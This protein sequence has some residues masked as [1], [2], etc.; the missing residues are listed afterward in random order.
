MSKDQRT[1][2]TATL[3]S[4]GKKMD[5][6]IGDYIRDPSYLRSEALAVAIKTWRATVQIAEAMAI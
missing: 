3:I 1:F 6:A 2:S 5:A 4:A